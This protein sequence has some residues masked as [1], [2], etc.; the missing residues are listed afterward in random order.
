MNKVIKFDNCNYKVEYKDKENDGNMGQI[1]YKKG[2]IEIDDSMPDDI[3]RMTLAHECT[4]M[5]L[6]NLGES[7]LNDNEGF[8]ERLSNAFLRMYSDNRDLLLPI[9]D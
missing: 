3:K 9:K 2:L 7:E 5:I 1:I 6:L 8:V 4:H